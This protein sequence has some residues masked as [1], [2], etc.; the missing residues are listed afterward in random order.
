MI[1]LDEQ[2]EQDVH[3]IKALRAVRIQS[4]TRSPYLKRFAQ[5]VFKALRAVRLESAS[6]RGDIEFNHDVMR[7]P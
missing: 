2:G 6:R 4:A 5:S 7:S 3:K 1:E